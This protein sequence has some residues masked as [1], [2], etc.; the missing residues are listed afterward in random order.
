M[1]TQKVFVS[2]SVTDIMKGSCCR[3]SEMRQTRSSCALVFPPKL[4]VSLPSNMFHILLLWS[5][6]LSGFLGFLKNSF[7][8]REEEEEE[9]GALHPAFGSATCPARR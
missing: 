7:F 9:E 3:W 5:S 6:V 8:S 1:L 4:L 2:S